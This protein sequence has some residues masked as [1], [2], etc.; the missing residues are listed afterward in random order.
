MKTRIAFAL[1]IAVPA[2]ADHLCRAEITYKWRRAQEEKE[3]EVILQA[4][5]AKGSDEASAKAEIKKLAL[6]ARSG[7]QATCAQRHENLT[8]CI[9]SKLAAASTVQHTLS[10]SARKTLE[11]AI[12]TDCSNSQGVCTEIIV[13]D[14]TCEEIKLAAT[15]TPTPEEKGKKKK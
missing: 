13:K 1:L 11:E 14:P 2:F 6:S 7:A 9:S 8:G 12:K 15:P 4:L 3:S 10:F 5:E